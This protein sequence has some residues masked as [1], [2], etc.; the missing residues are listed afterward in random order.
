M[1][2]TEA[3]VAV[4]GGMGLMGPWVQVLDRRVAVMTAMA[5]MAV[6]TRRGERGR[7]NPAA[8]IFRLRAAVISQSFSPGVLKRPIGRMRGWIP[9][10]VAGRRR[11]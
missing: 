4:V 5:T 9:R 11:A 3:P 8:D 10:L 6:T 2:A 7:M 1:T